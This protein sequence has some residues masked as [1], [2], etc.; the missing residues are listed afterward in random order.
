MSASWP[1]APRDGSGT[2][3]TW[4]HKLP[5]KF[6]E[7]KQEPED[8]GPEA[9]ANPIPAWLLN[10]GCLGDLKPTPVLQE[11]GPPLALLAQS[12]PSINILLDNKTHSLPRRAPPGFVPAQTA[13]PP[14]MGMC[15]ISEELEA[16]R[17]RLQELEVLSKENAAPQAQSQYEPEVFTAEPQWDTPVNH[18]SFSAP[19]ATPF[20]D[21][22]AAGD[23]VNV[24]YL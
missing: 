24:R 13:A 18:S 8:D 15:S 17:R 22:V 10:D 19:L 6:T 21:R 3:Q 5:H 9:L 1:W 2:N 20:W 4:G 14:R 11:P 7:V 12:P 16:T 23:S